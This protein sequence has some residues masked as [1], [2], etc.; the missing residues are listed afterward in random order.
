MDLLSQPLHRVPV[1]VLDFEMTGLDPQ[2]DRVC[3]VAVVRGTGG[4]VLHRWESLVNPRAKMS[5]GARKVHGITEE[6]LRK[7][8]RFERI[9]ETLAE[10]LE[11][12]VLVCHNVP[13]DIGF[14]HREMDDAGVPLTPLVSL[15]T[16]LMAR[17]LF[18]FR[19]NSLA[20]V[21]QQLGIAHDGAHRAMGDAQATFDVFHTMVRAIDPR[22]D[23]TVDEL[24]ELL[25][26]LAPNSPLRLEQKRVVREAFQRRETV[27]MDYQSTGSREILPVR[28]EVA[29][30]RLRLPYM[31]GWCFLREGERVFRLDRVRH[32]EHAGRPYAIPEFEPRI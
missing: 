26:A 23:V 4:E 9:A 12:A 30:W 29:L 5:R 2:R 13:F 32:V 8:P 3:E 17:R 18:A 28:R 14:L 15:D 1:A 19:R 20:N 10:H 16:L 24:L 6:M 11:G 31:Q 22:G 21:C 27:R 25:G 7:S